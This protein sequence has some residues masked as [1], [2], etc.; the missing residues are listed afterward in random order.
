MEER[1]V[2]Q[3]AGALRCRLLVRAALAGSLALFPFAAPA[4]A[5]GADVL[6]AG[7]GKLFSRGAQVEIPVSYRCEEGRTAGVGIFLTQ[8]DYHGAEVVG[9]A[10]SG[11][12]PCT[13]ET[14]TVTMTVPAGNGHFR[15]GAASA[16]LALV[17]SGAGTPD[18]TEQFT[19]DIRLRYRK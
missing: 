12:R 1:H 9:G 18:E 4:H 11:P 13:G 14:E 6:R 10:G 2:S 19:A 3:L 7:N 17:T 5:E 8:A 16:S 15:R